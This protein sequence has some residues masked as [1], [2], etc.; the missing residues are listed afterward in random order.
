MPSLI[1]ELRGHIPRLV[2]VVGEANAANAVVRQVHAAGLPAVLFADEAADSRRGGEVAP[3]G[4]G[5]TMDVADSVINLIGNTP[6]VRLDRI[7]RDLVATFWPSSS[8]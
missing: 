3:D 6:M 7:G 2:G 4:P 8:T 5:P 1:A